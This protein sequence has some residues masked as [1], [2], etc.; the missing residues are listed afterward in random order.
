MQT[1]GHSAGAASKG[2]PKLAKSEWDNFI[3]MCADVLPKYRDDDGRTAA[4][5]RTSARK[6]PQQDAGYAELSW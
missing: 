6:Q 4:L 3:T 1:D 5:V 2:T